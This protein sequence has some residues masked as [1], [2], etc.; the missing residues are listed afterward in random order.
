M[1]L[2]DALARGPRNNLHALRLALA[3]AVVVSH[4]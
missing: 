2:A 4:A 1:T 3:A